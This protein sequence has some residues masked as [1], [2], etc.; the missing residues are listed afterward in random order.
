MCNWKAK[1]DFSCRKWICMTWC[2]NP[3]PLAPIN[4]LNKT[5]SVSK[6]SCHF[7][8]R[9]SLFWKGW[10]KRPAWPHKPELPTFLAKYFG[11]I[12]SKTWSPSQRGTVTRSTFSDST[13]WVARSR[14]IK[15]SN[16]SHPVAILLSW[17]SFPWQRTRQMTL[18]QPADKENCLDLVWAALKVRLRLKARLN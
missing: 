15:F 18:L 13:R 11:V 2:I 6:H 4:H 9:L 1:H 3:V 10:L 17:L 12:G 8:R 16:F 7:L 5:R 14:S